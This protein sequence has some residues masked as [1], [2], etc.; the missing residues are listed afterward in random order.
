VM[1][2]VPAG[3]CVRQMRACGTVHADSVRGTGAPA[4]HLGLQSDMDEAGGPPRGRLTDTILPGADV[5]TRE[6]LGLSGWF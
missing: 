3:S 4:R 2:Q 5:E 1:L 6:L